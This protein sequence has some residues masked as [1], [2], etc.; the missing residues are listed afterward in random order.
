ME[1]IVAYPKDM[2]IIKNKKITTLILFF[3]KIFDAFSKFEI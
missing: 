2:S 3:R 1:F